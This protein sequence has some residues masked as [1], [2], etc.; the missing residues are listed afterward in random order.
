MYGFKGGPAGIMKFK[1][2]ELTS[3]VINIYRNQVKLC[4]LFIV[5]SD[6]SA[7]EFICQVA[8]SLILKFPEDNLLAT[9]STCH[10]SIY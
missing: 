7:Y 8:I 9:N 5:I 3:D 10:G 1:Y 6:I 2:V 4:E